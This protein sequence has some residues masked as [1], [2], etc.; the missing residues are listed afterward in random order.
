M[1]KRLLIAESLLL[2]GAI[3]AVIALMPG[4]PRFIVA[5]Q[6]SQVVSVTALWR[7]EMKDVGEIQPGNE[8]SFTVDDEAAM[9]FSVLH[10]DGSVER[11]KPIYFTSGTEVNAIVTDSG[12]H[13]SYDFES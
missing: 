6:M 12:I 4:A 7:N 10:V 1:P 3:V 13:L 9:I 5:N 8:T 2:C 11:S